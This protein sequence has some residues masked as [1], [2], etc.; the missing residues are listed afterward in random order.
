ME[1]HV[2]YRQTYNTTALDVKKKSLGG[3]MGLMTRGQ[4]GFA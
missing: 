4:T 1:N 2:K 3:A